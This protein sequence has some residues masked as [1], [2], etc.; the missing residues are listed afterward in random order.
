ME[1]KFYIR[2]LDCANCAKK[3][4]NAINK[5]EDVIHCDLSFANELLINVY[6]TCILLP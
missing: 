3:V 6:S 4:E 2:N 5:R 1:K